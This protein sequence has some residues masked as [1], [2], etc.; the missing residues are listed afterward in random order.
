MHAGLFKLNAFDLNASVEQSDPLII[1][2]TRGNGWLGRGYLDPT[3]WAKFESSNYN[4]TS[5]DIELRNRAIFIPVI[6]VLLSFFVG[7]LRQD[8]NIAGVLLV[9]FIIGI[10]ACVDL[11]KKSALL[12][13]F[14]E[15]V[16]NS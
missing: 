15:L 10:F 3:L 1:K 7:L 5:I 9:I 13:R 6:I 4:N 16:H 12:K 11:Y 14:E 2:F 8:Y